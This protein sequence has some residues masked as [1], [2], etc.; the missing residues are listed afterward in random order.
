MMMMMIMIIIVIITIDKLQKYTD[1]N[2]ELIRISPQTKLTYVTPQAITAMCL[3]SNKS[4]KSLKLLNL[5]P[6]LFVPK[7]KAVTLNSCS[8]V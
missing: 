5:R 2:E 6:A 1:L 7:H 4:H 8:T 3:I